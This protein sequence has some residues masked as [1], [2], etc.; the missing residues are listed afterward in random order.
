MPRGSSTPSTV[1]PVMYR[2]AFAI[3]SS[4]TGSVA[5]RRSSAQIV[6][7]ASSIRFVSTPAWT[8]R[9]PVSV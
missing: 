8:Y 3:S 1:R 7:I 6:E 9:A 4:G 2:F 5:I